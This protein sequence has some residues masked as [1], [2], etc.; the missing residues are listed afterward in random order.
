MLGFA[1][2]VTPSFYTCPYLLLSVQDDPFSALD[3]HL[4]DH[5]M[6]AGILELLRDDKRTVVLVT[7]KLQY[8]P[9]A[10]WVRG[11]RDTTLRGAEVG[12]AVWHLPGS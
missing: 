9:H 8:L 11:H 7:H 4:S 5:L 3:V 12:E 2:T 1:L 10:D 6:Q